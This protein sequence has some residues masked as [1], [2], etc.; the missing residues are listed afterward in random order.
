M[1]M[2]KEHIITLNSQALKILKEQKKMK[3]NDY[4]FAG[5]SKMGVIARISP[6]I[7]IND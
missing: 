2:R 6:V 3:V 5:S 1:K 4:I 7:S